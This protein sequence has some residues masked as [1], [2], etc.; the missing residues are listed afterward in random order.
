MEI[1]RPSAETPEK[2]YA[3][4]KAT[5]S[6]TSGTGSL[7]VEKWGL[8]LGLQHF[9]I[10]EH[11]LHQ[12]THFDWKWLWLHLRLLVGGIF[13]F[14]FVFKKKKKMYVYCAQCFIYYLVQHNKLSHFISL[15]IRWRKWKNTKRRR[16]G[17]ETSS[18]RS[19][20]I[21]TCGRSR[22]EAGGAVWVIATERCWDG[23]CFSPQFKQT[24]FLCHVTKVLNYYPCFL[25]YFWNLSHFNVWFDL[26]L[27]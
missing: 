1:R 27:H 20:S 5:L 19:K 10:F 7:T 12:E 13:Y 3:M 23:F 22:R 25:S 16:G 26:N 9:N 11:Y 6:L 17:M 24:L 18:R 2:T 8:Q 15:S 4:P 14:F 21:V